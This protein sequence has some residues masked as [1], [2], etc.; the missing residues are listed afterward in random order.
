MT[1]ASWI[2][3]DGTPH[4][5]SP[6]PGFV[7]GPDGRWSPP[8]ISAPAP[9]PA[10]SPPTPPP[11]SEASTAAWHQPVP[12]PVADGPPT[13]PPT[14]GPT[15]PWP[16]SAPVHHDLAAQAT[17][18]AS[19]DDRSLLVLGGVVGAAFLVLL[20]S[21]AF[22]LTRGDP[23]DV[24]ADGTTTVVDSADPTE[25]PTTA[26]PG[27]ASPTTEDGRQ[28]E[29]PTTTIAADPGAL[30]DIAG[31][32]RV[33]PNTVNIEIVSSADRISD[34][35]LTVEFFAD[36][37]SVVGTEQAFFNHVRP[38]ERVIEDEY[39]FEERGDRCRV[40]EADR[41]DSWL[42]I[43][44]I[45][46]VG[47]CLITG[48]DIAGDLT[49]SVTV[50]HDDPEPLD[51][52]IALAFVD[53]MGIRLGEG[54]GFVSAVQPGEPAP[55]D[56]W[57]TVSAATADVRCEVVGVNVSSTDGGFG[58][59]PAALAAVTSCVV[60]DEAVV[61]RV[62][63][64]RG[65]PTDYWVSVVIYA[66]GER[67]DDTTAFIDSIPPG[68]TADERVT[69]FET[70]GDSCEAVSADAYDSFGSGVTEATATC[71]VT[72]ADSFDDV[73]GVFSIT[74]NDATRS[75][76]TL[77]L[78]FYDADGV[79]KGSTSVLVEGVE[80]GATET[81]DF[82]TFT[83]YDDSYTCRIDLIDPNTP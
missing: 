2:D 77:G 34:Y 21:I 32:A 70:D 39:M 37:G 60:T 35:V 6:P 49:A 27:T 59:D 75:D 30:A 71:E 41:S 24:I 4:P 38:G 83:P 72:G 76:Y 47:D 11:A 48:E 43:D 68:V 15:A 66:D 46:D 42:T 7:L 16:D 14:S 79:R 65:V 74:N 33:D 3:A 36:D 52:S 45:G 26:T 29:L 18:Q 40:V 10:V 53:E 19:G 31:C 5:G 9:P 80:P 13:S 23:D 1:D 25:P 12:P 64:D 22:F 67:V 56:V 20:G 57:T 28:S 44:R 58:D 62:T 73:E 63:N 69:L 51:Y 50:S 55:T 82:I 81:D 17:A 78:G 61:V 54:T 8:R